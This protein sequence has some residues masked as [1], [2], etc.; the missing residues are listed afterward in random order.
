MSYKII[1]NSVN[2]LQ[3]MKSA[4]IMDKC[5]QNEVLVPANL[6]RTPDSRNKLLK[7]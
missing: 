5:T 4:R 2:S 3:N 1:Y 7:N 6:Y